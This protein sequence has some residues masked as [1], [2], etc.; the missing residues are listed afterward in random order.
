MGF[1][2]MDRKGS[3]DSFP[4]ETEKYIGRVKSLALEKSI[5]ASYPGTVGKEE[6]FSAMCHAKVRWPSHVPVACETCLDLK[7][8]G[9]NSVRRNFTESVAAWLLFVQGLILLSEDKNPR[10]V[11]EALQAWI[12]VLVASSAHVT[13]LIPSSPPPRQQPRR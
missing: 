10:V 11:Y 4:G 8:P 5:S 13:P 9:E 1:F 12:P 7:A 6:L 3:P 2:G